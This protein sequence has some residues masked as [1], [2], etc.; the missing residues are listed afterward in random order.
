MYAIIF[1]PIKFLPQ[2]SPNRTYFTYCFYKR[3]SDYCSPLLLGLVV[4]TSYGSEPKSNRIVT[5]WVDLQLFFQFKL[6]ACSFCVLNSGM[7]AFRYRCLVQNIGLV[8]K[9][10]TIW[11]G[12][13]LIKASDIIYR[14]AP[15]VRK[16]LRVINEFQFP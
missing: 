7:T 10:R 1:I 3:I 12:C 6:Y 9:H 5:H 8:D 13:H 11:E 2:P 15:I 14:A 4:E 16:R